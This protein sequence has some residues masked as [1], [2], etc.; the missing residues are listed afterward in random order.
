VV[1]LLAPKH[2]VNLAT[3]VPNQATDQSTFT[4]WIPSLNLDLM[5][6]G[7]LDLLQAILRLQPSGFLHL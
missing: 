4:D 3:L 5:H 2:V 6:H 7:S 1:S